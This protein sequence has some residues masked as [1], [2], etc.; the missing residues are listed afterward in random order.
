[1]GDP[2]AVSVTPGA[3]VAVP[4]NDPVTSPPPSGSPATC[5]PRSDD[6]PPALT[7]QSTAPAALAGSAVIS[8]T[9]ASR[10][11]PSVSRQVEMHRIMGVS[12]L[13]HRVL[14]RMPGACGGW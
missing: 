14:C 12:F 10:Q 11:K 6:V 9:H 7:A 8:N 5:V 4:V 13:L 2:V 1:M 3:K